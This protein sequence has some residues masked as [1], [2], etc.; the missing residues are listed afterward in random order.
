[1]QS[2]DGNLYGMTSAGG[3][4]NVGTFFKYGLT[5]QT[6]TVLHSFAQGDGTYPW[7]NVI[8]ATD[9]N[10]YGITQQGGSGNAGTI[11]EFDLT[12]QALVVLHAFTG[13]PG[14]G[15]DSTGS[16]IQASDG[17]FYGLTLKGG[18][19]GNAGTLFVLQ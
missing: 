4:N 5:S 7:G 16:L 12:T 6:V 10:F 2:G 9:G 14:D 19:N 15:A 3:T 17:N 1:M 13:S 11:F 8:Q 18:A